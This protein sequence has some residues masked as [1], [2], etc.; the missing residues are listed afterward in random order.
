MQHHHRMS[1]RDHHAGRARAA[2]TIMTVLAVAGGVL[3]GTAPAQAVKDRS[4]AYERGVVAK[5]NKARAARGVAKVRV[6]SCVDQIAEARARRM[7]RIARIGSSVTTEQCARVL[8]MEATASRRARPAAVVRGWLRRSATRAALLDPGVVAVGIGATR[9]RAWH[10]NLLLVGPVTSSSSDDGSD[11][12]VDG[13]TSDGGT[14]DGGTTDGGTTDGGTGGT[15]DAVE[16]AILEE[17]NRRRADHGLAPLQASSCATTFAEEVTSNMVAVDDLVHADLSTLRSRCSVSG[18][19]EN[20]AALT[21]T[22]LDAA[23]VVQMWMDS[24]AHRANILDP[25]L[26]HLGVGA[27]Q[28]AASG[29]WYVTQ[30]FL[31]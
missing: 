23:T 16:S 20:I 1:S 18:A 11:D 7:P 31:G 26:T 24:T 2:A 6:V 30:D 10:V 21:A 9:S 4:A 5:V 19:A 17:T 8:R 14:T 12:G 13:G 29:R 15:T 27:A 22:T 25:A 28:N 3:A